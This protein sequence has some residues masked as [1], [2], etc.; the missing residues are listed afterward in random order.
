[1]DFKDPPVDFTGLARSLGMAAERIDDPARLHD[2]LTRAYAARAPRLI[3][4]VVDGTV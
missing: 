1:M 4:I 2:A 3:E